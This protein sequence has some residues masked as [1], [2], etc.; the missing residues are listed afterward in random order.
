[1]SRKILVVT[2]GGRH[3]AVAG[4][5]EAVP[6]LR[7]AGF[8]VLLHD[9]DLAVELGAEK[10]ELDDTKSSLDGAELVMVLGGD[11][12]ILRAAEITHGTQVPLLGVNLG[13][14][15]FL[16]ESE[17]ED[18]RDAVRRLADHDYAVEERGVLDV[19]V[20]RPGGAEPIHDW[21]L[22]EATIE[23]HER[24]LMIEVSIEV[25]GRPL[26]SF[27]C[28]GVVMA[29]ATGSTAHAFSAGGPVMWPDVDAKLLVPIS[30]HALFARPLVVGPRSEFAVEVT[31]RSGAR[32][33]LITDG[34]RRTELPVGSRVEVR[35]SSMPLRFARLNQAPFTDRLVSKFSLPVAGWREVA[36]AR[37]AAESR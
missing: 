6:E 24:T 19:L 29:T 36:D 25:D 27:G 37:R 34:R 21:A 23:K 28:D 33:V 31:A 12:T 15:G 22:N 4:L 18:L 11:G 3:E 32:G 10:F 26:S 13:H 7:A 16:A 9:H 1:M 30:A 14:I 5:R 2:H 8:E 35:T 17:R 20:Q